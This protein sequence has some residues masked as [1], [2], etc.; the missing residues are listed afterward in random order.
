MTYYLNPYTLIVKRGH[1]CYY[2]YNDIPYFI[3]LKEYEILSEG[4]NLNFTEF[5]SFERLNHFIQTR[6]V[7]NYDAKE[8]IN[9]L[10]YLNKGWFEM[11][12]FQENDY[13]KIS[14]SRILILGCGGTGTHV[15]WNLAAL[16]IRDFI[17]IDDDKVELNNFNRQLLYDLN[18]IGQYK[19][20]A[21]KKKLEERFPGINI[22]IWKRRVDNGLS[23][24]DFIE[25]DTVDLV[26]KG[27][28]T[29]LDS[30]YE[31]G[32]YFYSRKIKYVCGGT[33]GTKLFLGPTFSPSLP[34]RFRETT[35]YLSNREMGTSKRIAGK[36]VSLPL[37]F[38]YIGSMLSREIILLLTDNEHLVSYNDQI[39]IEN[40][41]DKRHDSS[42][43]DFLKVITRIISCSLVVLCIGYGN[44][45]LRIL[46]V[47]LL[48]L[49]QFCLKE[50]E[51][52]SFIDY[53]LIGFF[54][55]LNANIRQIANLPFTLENV[56]SSIFT[57]LSATCY[58]SML[59]GLTKF[60]LEAIKRRMKNWR[61]KN[62]V[63]D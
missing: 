10:G 13:K 5:I 24:E 52:G 4:L 2:Y 27:I 37:F 46:S 57:I 32:E 40:I 16:G 1:G 48:F 29:P 55:G 34:N 36:A 39:V 53:L 47:L 51:K 44:N 22:S 42:Q 60:M 61:K 3:T 25:L 9:S 63:K 18:D 38:G 41:F 6:L 59:F 45:L 50:S 62:R 14:S 8:A 56:V 35:V 49:I 11:S 28:D 26:V 21:L 54:L 23:L 33:V 31:F 43:S 7:I 19:V 12:S 15:A 17:L 20:E 30:M 58:F